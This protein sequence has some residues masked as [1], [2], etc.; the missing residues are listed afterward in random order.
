MDVSRKREVSLQNR[1]RYFV[2]NHDIKQCSLRENIFFNDQLFWFLK[3]TQD[4]EVAVCGATMVKGLKLPKP[5]HV[6]I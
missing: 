3:Y 1:Y 2:S 6:E 5:S 4:L